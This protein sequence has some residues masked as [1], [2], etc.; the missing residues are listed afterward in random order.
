MLTL[1]EHSASSHMHAALKFDINATSW[2]TGLS[3]LS[4]AIRILNDK[5]IEIVQHLLQNNAD[6]NSFDL[7]GNS[8]LHEAA[9]LFNT[10]SKAYAVDEDAMQQESAVCLELVKMLVPPK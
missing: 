6:P 8:C 10:L 5:S 4:Y 3:A 1:L 7:K 2:K 9:Y